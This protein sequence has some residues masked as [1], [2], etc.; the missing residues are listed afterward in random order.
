M[1]L[2]RNSSCVWYYNAI[3]LLSPHSTLAPLQKVP[4]RRLVP[5][6]NGPSWAPHTPFPPCIFEAKFTGRQTVGIYRLQA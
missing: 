3:F 4:I 2:V 6:N 5:R 1:E